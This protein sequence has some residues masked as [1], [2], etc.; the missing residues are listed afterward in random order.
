MPEDGP[1]GHGSLRS[2]LRRRDFRLVWAAQAV[3]DLGDGMTSLTLLLL[4]LQLTGSASAVAAVL[5]A[6][7][8][9]QVTIGLAAG[10]FVDRWERR[11]IM[12]CSDLIRVTIVLGFILVRS[13]EAMP[14]LLVLAFAEAAVGAFFSPARMAMIPAILPQEELFA[15]NSLAQLTRVMAA[16]VGASLAG[17]MFGTMGVSWPAF[18]G[19]A[20]T[21]LASA[22][23]VSRAS[24]RSRPVDAHGERGALTGFRDGILA[25]VRSPAL[26]ATL[27]G[28]AVLMLGLGVV[29]VLWV[30]LFQNELHVPTVLFGASDG[31]QVAAMFLA[32]A[33]TGAISRRFRPTVLVPLCLAGLGLSVGLLSG[34]RSFPEVLVLLFCLGLMLAP[35][36][37]AIATIVQTTTPPELLG[38]V[39]AA[40]HAVFATANVVSL[41]LAGAVSAFLGLRPSFVASGAVALIAAVIAAVLFASAG[42]ER[43]ARS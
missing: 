40:L 15:A 17:I 34:V 21:F 37:A 33:A 19:D 3:S 16:V 43:T 41:A 31:A 29:N 6:V 38:R 28:A 25:I 27:I 36:N 30:P 14:L 8:L 11:R 32:T 42:R 9:P 5:I 18:V 35:L 1:G 2:P 7:A 13:R 4:A 20:A 10:V 39:S 23:L 12:V 22:A 24:A 26:I